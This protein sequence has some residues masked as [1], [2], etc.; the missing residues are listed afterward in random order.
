MNKDILYVTFA[1]II[2][3]VNDDSVEVFVKDNGLPYDLKEKTKAETDLLTGNCVIEYT[4]EKGYN[5]VS[6]KWLK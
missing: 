4:C 1:D 6:M 2:C 5:L 3:K